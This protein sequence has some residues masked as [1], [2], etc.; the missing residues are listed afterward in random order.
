MTQSFTPCVRPS[1][2]STSGCF[3]D[4]ASAI[5]RVASDRLGP[6]LRLAVEAIE[7]CSRP[8]SRGNPMD[9]RPPGRGGGP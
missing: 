8:V 6:G 3:A 1:G 9:P 4:S 5:D 7:V 2:S